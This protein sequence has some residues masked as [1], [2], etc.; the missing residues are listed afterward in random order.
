MDLSWVSWVLLANSVTGLPAPLLDR[1]TVFRVGYPTG[2]HLRALVERELVPLDAA[3]A[4]VDRAIREI[5][6]GRLTLRALERIK[7]RMRELARR[8]MLH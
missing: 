8:P 3:P 7:A 1:V 5:E 4:V 6:A 2:K